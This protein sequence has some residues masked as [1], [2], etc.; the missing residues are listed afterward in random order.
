M[1]HTSNLAHRSQKR[2]LG[3]SDSVKINTIDD[4]MVRRFSCLERGSTSWE[5][6]NTATH[7]QEHLMLPLTSVMNAVSLVS[8]CSLRK[9]LLY[10]SSAR[11]ADIMHKLNGWNGDLD[12]ATIID[13]S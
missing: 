11:I 2:V 4:S 10:N 13:P 7:L 8:L 3:P 6:G 9:R 1:R 5:E 12:I